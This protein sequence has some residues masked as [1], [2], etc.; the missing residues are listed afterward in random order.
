M[1]HGIIL[2][3]FVLAIAA[4]IGCVLCVMVGNRSFYPWH[5]PLCDAGIL[6]PNGRGPAL[7]TWRRLL[8]SEPELDAEAE[9]YRCSAKRWFLRFVGFGATF[10]LCVGLVFVLA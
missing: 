4:W 1:S 6:P 3:L 9:V 8:G 2:A 10:C 7:A 5:R